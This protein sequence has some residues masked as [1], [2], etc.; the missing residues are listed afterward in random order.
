MNPYFGFFFATSTL[1]I[2]ASDYPLLYWP[3]E[4]Y[5]RL[6]FETTSGV[7]WRKVLSVVQ[8]LD[9]TA[10]LTLNTPLGATPEEVDISKV[11]FLNLVRLASDI[12]TLTHGKIRTDIELSTRTVDA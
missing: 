4:T 11:S 5:K 3:F 2:A 12:V 10:T 1:I 6:Q 8:N 7:V 9:G